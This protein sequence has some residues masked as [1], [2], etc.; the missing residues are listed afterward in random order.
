VAG[1][2]CLDG[3]GGTE[4][5]ASASH[6]RQCGRPCCLG[7]RT[8]PGFEKLLVVMKD[9]TVSGLR[10]W[11]VDRVYR[12]M[13]DLERLI[14]VA[15]L[16]DRLGA[17]GAGCEGRMH[18]INIWSRICDDPIQPDGTWNRW[19]WNKPAAAGRLISQRTRE[20]LAVRKSQGVRL[21]RPPSVP[22]VVV[23]RIIDARGGG[24]SLRTIAASLTADGVPT[25]QGGAKWHASTIKAVLEGQDAAALCKPLRRDSRSA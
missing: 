9:G 15:E 13:R 1:A 14:G 8:R 17:D 10:I 5:D 11:R 22:R 12:S 19:V 23:E 25:A 24:D 2:A 16:A 3:A 6:F 21:G 4:T 20:A 7:G 18:S